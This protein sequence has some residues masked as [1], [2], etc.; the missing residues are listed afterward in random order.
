MELLSTF[1]FQFLCLSQ[2][3]FLPLSLRLSD[4]DY[5]IHSSVFSFLT[6]CI[7]NILLAIIQSLKIKILINACYFI[8][9]LY[10]C[11]Y[12]CSLSV[13]TDTH[14]NTAHSEAECI[15]DC[16]KGAVCWSTNL[17]KQ[18]RLITA[19][20]VW[21]SVGFRDWQTFKGKSR[22]TATLEMWLFQ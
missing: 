8:I 7:L 5:I 11:V 20:T 21:E 1:S 2:P 13:Y 14:T 6:L 19:R 17:T 4:Q 3:P 10:I 12:V 9:G 22:L 15:G 16:S 18:N